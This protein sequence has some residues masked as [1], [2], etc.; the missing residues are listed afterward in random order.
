MGNIPIFFTLSLS[1]SLSFIRCR[2]EIKVLKK[3]E[4]ERENSERR[5]ANA[6]MRGEKP[7]TKGKRGRGEKKKE[8]GLG[9]EHKNWG[10]QKNG[11]PRK[12]KTEKR[13]KKA[14]ASPIRWV[15]IEKQRG[16][17]LWVQKSHDAPPKY[18]HMA[19]QE[20]KKI[21]FPWITTMAKKSDESA[22]APAH[23]AAITPLP[24]LPLAVA[25][26][27]GALLLEARAANRP[28]NPQWHSPPLHRCNSESRSSKLDWTMVLATVPASET[29]HFCT[30]NHEPMDLSHQSDW[31]VPIFS[32][33]SRML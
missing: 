9:K 20:V 4:R 6:V 27:F 19:G 10:R 8:K 2:K 18:R 28:L 25:P 11:S 30:T 22:A 3:D 31:T 29:S 32:S 5:R 14:N 24:V 17:A 23:V 21:V 33:A 12:K 7:R 1:P 13:K 15:Q 16:E 26:L